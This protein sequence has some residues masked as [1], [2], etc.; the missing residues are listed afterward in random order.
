[1]ITVT[2]KLCTT[3]IVYSCVCLDFPQHWTKLDTTGGPRPPVRSSHAACCIAG[4]LTGQEH[5]LLLV[6]GGGALKDMW[7][8]DVDRGVWSEVSGLIVWCVMS[9]IKS[10]CYRY[11]LLLTHM[12]LCALNA[13]PLKELEGP[14]A[15]I[16]SGAHNI[17]CGRGSRKFYPQEVLHSLKCVLGA[18]EASFYASIQ[19][20]YTCKLLSLFI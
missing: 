14:R 15:N 7:V 13:G 11:V 4:P 1:M 5:P 6:G 12:W 17:D 8:L 10:M 20:I 19:Y 9:Y 18:S 16:K 2:R 3:F